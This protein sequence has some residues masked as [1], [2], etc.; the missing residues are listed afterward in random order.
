[1]AGSATLRV[2]A[3]ISEFEKATRKMAAE[4]KAIDSGLKANVAQ[5]KL[6]KN[7]YQGLSDQQKIYSEKVQLAN[8]QVQ[9]QKKNLESLEVTLTKQKR[10]QFDLSEEISK[11]TKAWKQSQ[12]LY[13]EN[14]KQAKELGDA[15][16]Q[17]ETKQKRNNNAMDTSNQK[18]SKAKQGLADAQ[19]GLYSAEIA[20]DKTNKQLNSFQMDE[21]TRKLDNGSTKLVSFGKSMT[22]NVT[23]PI[24]ALGTAVGLASIGFSDG[25]TKV[26]TIANLS[27][28]ELKN[29]STRMLSISDDTNTAAGSL[30]EG[31]YQALSSGVQITGDGAS[32]L[33]FLDRNARLAKAGF[34]ELSTTVDLTTTIINSYGK[35]Q[36][37]INN[38]SDIL[39]NTQNIG[40][41]TVNELA[42]S[43][44]Q[45]IPTAK[46][47]N[48]S[49]EQTA[50][51]M[52]VLTKNGI[53]TAEA[54][55]YFNE[56]LNE[57]GAAG[58]KA[59]DILQEKTGK[60]FRELM[61]DGTSLSDALGILDQSAKDNNLSM[62]DMFGSATAGRAAMVLYKD[63][64]LE[65]NDTLLK[66]N[67]SAG[68]TDAA[69]NMIAESTGEKARA[70]LNKLI[71]AGIKFGD[72]MAPA[73]ENVADL[74]SGLADLLNGLDEGTRAN[75]VS[76]LMFAA[77]VGPV[78]TIVG[79]LGQGL[80]RTIKIAGKAVDA[81]GFLK[82]SLVATSVTS[83]TMGTTF[84]GLSSG[85]TGLT[86]AITGT[87]AGT[88]GLAVAFPL[89]AMA[90][91]AYF[92][93]QRLI[94][95]GSM[96]IIDANGKVMASAQ[97]LNQEYTNGITTRA[98][99]LQSSVA[100][101]EGSKILITELF[102]LEQ[103]ENKTV[104]E[105]QR[106]VTLVDL[107]NQKMPELNLIIDDQ[108]GK[109]NATR[110]EIDQTVASYEKMARTAAGQQALIDNARGQYEAEKALK[111][112][113]EQSNII[114]DQKALIYDSIMH[115]GLSATDA[116]AA[117]AREVRQLTIEQNDNA[118]AIKET[119]K[120]YIGYKTEAEKTYDFINGDVRT[121]AQITE[122]VLADAGGNA[123][124]GAARA[125]VEQ[126]PNYKEALKGVGIAGVAGIGETK[127]D[128]KKAGE[129]NV[130]ELL[131]G[132][133][134]ATQPMHSTGADI[135]KKGSEGVSS[136]KD[137]Y[138]TGA[139][140]L[141]GAAKEGVESE[142]EN[143]K[144]A[145]FDVTKKGAARATE[146]T[147][148]YKQAGAG[149]GTALRDALNAEG[150]GIN[151]VA[152]GIGTN[153][154]TTANN[155]QGLFSNAGTT[156]GTNLGT[157]LAAMGGLVNSSSSGLGTNAYD[158]LSNL[159]GN[160][161]TR[162]SEGGQGVVNGI[163]N[164]LPSLRG[165]VGEVE[166]TI[167]NAS[168]WFPEIQWPTI[169]VPNF[170]MEGSF[171]LNPPSVPHISWDWAW[172]GG[173]YNNPT[174][175]GVGDKYKG[176]GSNPEAVVP[177]DQMYSEIDRIV[178][179]KIGGNANASMLAE[180][181]NILD[182]IN[183]KDSDILIDGKSI[184]QR[185]KNEMSIALNKMNSE[186]ATRKGYR[187][188]SG[189]V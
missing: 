187:V 119:E 92:E 109:L 40:K 12:E 106:M 81:F 34:S 73:I 146:N 144:T 26:N 133:M 30:T 4:M 32:A 31:F 74:I 101:I 3:N 140:A 114:T 159:G 66:I 56:M 76:M 45:L 121:E 84:T 7:A 141:I 131:N 77:A 96:S 55:T 71:N 117:Y 10:T 23:L 154:A 87:V 142:S 112:L 118:T 58:S 137:S 167:R 183:K 37:E 93:K 153:A 54:T 69:F 6:S 75:V 139:K 172:Q 35:S 63:S 46:G 39:I 8:S 127:P 165:T 135:G 14:S 184:V 151:G 62:S 123:I 20:L 152:A 105:K 129:V 16:D 157:S 113:T 99:Y 188:V 29:L 145:T 51:G 49:F 43:Y 2:G 120:S 158:A 9:N 17:L 91:G 80:S 176:R 166:S 147:P 150:G 5:A 85:A 155:Q 88:V 98:Q 68:A 15:L 83:G 79:K 59:G 86:T 72:T 97:T 38:I 174:L 130:K 11:T 185:T 182:E 168:L 128:Y 27:Q 53:R 171:S 33:S 82:K 110:G 125:A 50:T 179:N 160:M 95:D 48:V 103:Q 94:A 122:K 148:L 21:F 108:T 13:G 132:M 61:A 162:G 126:T 70:S 163:G 180:I 90:A 143:F 181:I 52:A 136:T 178:S 100:E 164:H 25:M 89:L 124:I 156:Y 173:I 161:T 169:K 65:F 60:S 67:N 104:G 138:K 42:Q 175:L 177:L 170:Y 36:D 1:M 44:G 22:T 186:S 78:T 19:A 28:D 41:T 149:Y 115:R 24:A 134:N 47:V 64:G 116:E 189:G 18:L 102:N 111:E 57:L 107:L